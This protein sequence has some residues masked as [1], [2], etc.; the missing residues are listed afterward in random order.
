MGDLILDTARWKAVT[1]IEAGAFDA[2]NAPPVGGPDGNQTS[3]SQ[4]TRVGSG[5]SPFSAKAGDSRNPQDRTY[6]W[7]LVKVHASGKVRIE[8]YGFD[9]HYGKTT[10]LKIIRF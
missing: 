9:E 3:Q 1:G 8:V 4:L 6:A 7:A 5:G 10:R 2:A